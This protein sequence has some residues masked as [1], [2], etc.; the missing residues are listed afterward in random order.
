M[1]N[2]TLPVQLSLQCIASGLY[3][4]SFHRS[5]IAFLSWRPLE[6]SV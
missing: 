5:A 4:I 2:V 6:D 1:S 3:K